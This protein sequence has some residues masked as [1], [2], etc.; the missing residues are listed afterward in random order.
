MKTDPSIAVS[1]FLSWRPH[2]STLSSRSNL[3]V[4]IVQE[5]K[6]TAQISR[7]SRTR[8]VVAIAF[9]IVW[10][11]L[12]GSDRTPKHPDV[13]VLVDTALAHSDL[14]AVKVSQHRDVGV[15]TLTGDVPSLAQKAEAEGLAAQAAP[16]YTIFN[17]IGARSIALENQASV[18]SSIDD[19]MGKNLKQTS[20]GYENVD[21]VNASNDAKGQ[22][23]VLKDRV[24]I[25]RQKQ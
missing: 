10:F 16:G 25:A 8:I 4:Q 2:A 5:G 7:E 15:L 11:V 12:V 18:D 6:L 13:K 19:V 23:P 17:D 22:T 21:D 20:K 9:L 1:Y 3:S 24:R 14:G